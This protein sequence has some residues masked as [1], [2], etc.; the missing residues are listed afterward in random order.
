M[1]VWQSRVFIPLS[2]DPFRCFL[3]RGRGWHGFFV[4]LFIPHSHRSRRWGFAFVF[5]PPFFLVSL[6][7]VV[8]WGMGQNWKKT[9]HLSLTPPLNPASFFTTPVPVLCNLCLHYRFTQS[10]RHRRSRTG[11]PH[12]LTHCP[13]HKKGGV[14]YWVE[15]EEDSPFF[16]WF[17][18]PSLLHFPGFIFF[19]HKVHMWRAEKG[20]EHVES[21]F[22]PTRTYPQSIVV[23]AGAGEGRHG[24]SV[25]CGHRLAVAIG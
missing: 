11:A 18:L 25:C 24:K 3:H 21:F 15:V 14:E 13:S 17:S 5:L 23:R 7:R 20:W 2:H 4:P 1:F 19:A 6:V 16:V 10:L 12:A 9:L 8:L 22:P